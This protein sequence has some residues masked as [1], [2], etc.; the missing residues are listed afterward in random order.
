MLPRRQM[1]KLLIPELFNIHARKQFESC[2]QNLFSSL[3]ISRMKNVEKFL[4]SFIQSTQSSLDVANLD[5][6]DHLNTKVFW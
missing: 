3:R 4:L 6:A 5:L 1:R 2:Q